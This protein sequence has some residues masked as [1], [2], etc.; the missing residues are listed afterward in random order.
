VLYAVWAK[1]CKKLAKIVISDLHISDKDI[2][3][4]RSRLRRFPLQNI[5]H[6]LQ[7]PHFLLVNKAEMLTVVGTEQICCWSLCMFM[8]THKNDASSAIINLEN[9]SVNWHQLH[10]SG[11]KCGLESHVWFKYILFHGHYEK[12]TKWYSNSYCSWRTVRLTKI[13]IKNVNNSKFG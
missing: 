12:R 5:P 6:Q 13:R 9:Y 4:E 3:A 2:C 8:S 7:L 10:S 11:E 1:C